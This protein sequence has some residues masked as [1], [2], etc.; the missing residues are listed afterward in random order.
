MKSRIFVTLFS[1]AIIL[2]S[3]E[4]WPHARLADNSD[5][6]PRGTG[7]KDS[8]CGENVRTATPKI[9]NAG[10]QIT[11]RW[12][13]TVDHTGSFWIE[14]SKANDKNW[15]RL[16]TVTDDQNNAATI[17]HSFEAT[18]TVPNVNCNNCTL[19]IVQEMID[20]HPDM[21]SYYYSCGDIKIVNAK[22]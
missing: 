6:P 13:E 2:F 18:I 17:P 19:R 1:S 21:P 14:Y 9:L 5:V 12:I 20:G 8:P 11:I 10:S 7:M 15:I 4:S 3:I 16:K 22:C